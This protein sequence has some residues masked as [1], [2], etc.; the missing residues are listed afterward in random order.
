MGPDLTKILQQVTRS[1]SGFGH[2]RESS[3]PGSAWERTAWQALP[4]ETTPREAE[5]RGQCVPRQSLGTR[6]NRQNPEGRPHRWRGAR[7]PH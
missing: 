7:A 6:A 5:P 3:F 2:R 4:A 1:P